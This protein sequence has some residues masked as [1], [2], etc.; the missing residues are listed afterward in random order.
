MPN[1]ILFREIIPFINKLSLLVGDSGES[2]DTFTNQYSYIIMKYIFLLTIYRLSVIINNIDE[3]LESNPDY[4]TI[5]EIVKDSRDIYTRFNIEEN[6]TDSPAKTIVSKLVFDMIVNIYLENNENENIKL[7][8]NENKLNEIIT[9]EKER[10]KV[11]VVDKLTNMDH[12]KRGIEIQLQECGIK[13]IYKSKEADNLE[14]IQSDA[15]QE[16][17]MSGR[18]RLMGDTEMVDD[19]IEEHEFEQEIQVDRVDI[20]MDNN[21]DSGEEGY[22]IDDYAS[23]EQE[24]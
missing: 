24:D 1:A 8:Y 9:K 22:G 23:D 21:M 2:D 12:E 13:N 7:Y 19:I 17:R 15:Y 16:F 6:D 4:N 10:E 5:A 11:S 20:I 3:D 18:E 14:W